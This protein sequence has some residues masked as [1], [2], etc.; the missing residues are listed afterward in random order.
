MIRRTIRARG[1]IGCRSAHLIDVR[2][3]EKSSAL[4]ARRQSG[5]LGAFTGK[6]CI[7]GDHEPACPLDQC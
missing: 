1:R 5:E 7:G 4:R 6:E 3:S 2:T